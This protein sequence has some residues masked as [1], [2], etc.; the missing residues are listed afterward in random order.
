MISSIIKKLII[1]EKELESYIELNKCYGY[2]EDALQEIQNTINI[3]EK[4]V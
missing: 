1:C 3:L 4:G 2:T